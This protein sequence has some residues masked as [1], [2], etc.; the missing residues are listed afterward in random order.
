MSQAADACT[1]VPYSG[2]Q[3]V[4]WWGHGVASASVV[5][6][7]HRRDGSTVARAAETDG[8]EAGTTQGQDA[9][10]AAQ[11]DGVLWLSRQLLTLMQANFSIAYAGR[12]SV[13]GRT[14]QMVQ[15]RRPDGTLAATFWLDAATKLPLRREIFDESSRMISEDAFIS[16]AM[17]NDAADPA[18]DPDGQP[19]TAPL[20]RA[21]L[22]ALR[23]RGWPLPARLGG[24]LALFAA[25]RS[26]APSGEVVDLS[27]SDGLSVISLFVQRGQLPAAM[28]GW[29]SIRTG[30]HAVFAVD[31]DERS[32]AWSARGFVY[33]VIADAPASTV[34]AVVA[35][36]PHQDQA[37]FWGRLTRGFKRLASWANPFG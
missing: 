37:G 33:T 13:D 9:Q 11:E 20:S 6:V 7:W 26:V 25:S 3:V 8:A 32:L 24:G 30:G 19:W 10:S 14:A 5:Q 17:G 1:A 35:T 34:S 28:P 4:A 23:A 27:Y 29:H 22:R 15:L 31:P 12:A 18:P 16:V 21:S 2:V 36:L